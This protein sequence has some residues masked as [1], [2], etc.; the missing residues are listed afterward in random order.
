MCDKAFHTYPFVFYST[1]DS[2]VIQELCEKVVFEDS[3]INKILKKCAIKLF[4]VIY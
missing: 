3:F 4:A 2:Y 1:A